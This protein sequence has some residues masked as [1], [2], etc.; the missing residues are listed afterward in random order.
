MN[1]LDYAFAVARIRVKEKSLLTDADVQQ[2]C[3]MK[4]EEEILAFLRDRE[5]G[6]A[7]EDKGAAADLLAAEEEKNW[8]LMKELHV[9]ES[10][11]SV[12]S[13]PQLYHN[14][15]AAIKEVATTK[16]HPA[17]FYADAEIGREEMLRIIRDKAYVDLPEHMRPAAMKAYETMTQTLDG[18]MADVI[19]DRACL[20]AMQAAAEDADPVVKDYVNQTAIVSAIKVAVRGAA[21]GK[22]LYFLKEAL[23]S[24]P[25]LS[26]DRLAQAASEGVDALTEFLVASGFGEAA[27][28][29][30]TSPS[31]FERWCDNA[32][33][34]TLRP[35][36][37]N[38]FSVGPVI[39]Y[40][41][42][43]ENEIKT[44]RIILTG[45][46]NDFPEEEIRERVRNMYG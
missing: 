1:E 26:A 28:A 46:A 25:G 44:A 19:V 42:A 36:K 8:A 33:I 27:E 38:A 3:G 9:D 17:A 34:E 10:V 18:Q 40:F 16:E 31:A 12:L 7:G 32:L 5:W 6:V 11:F 37:R 23:P 35:Q 21:T 39:A 14:L 15:K 22:S 2:M 4:S 24:A 41:L 29:I 13:F 20:T 45:K 43:R 30:R